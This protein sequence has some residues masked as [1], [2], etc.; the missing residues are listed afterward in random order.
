MVVVIFWC[1]GGGGDDG[2][3]RGWAL[4]WVAAQASGSYLTL[5]VRVGALMFHR[6]L[7]DL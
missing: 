7:H 1:G 3:R 5:G 2:V 6:K 4:H